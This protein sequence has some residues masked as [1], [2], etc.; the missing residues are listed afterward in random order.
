[1]LVKKNSWVKIETILLNPEERT[2]NLPD[3]T[4]KVPYLYHSIGYLKEDAKIGDIVEIKTRIGRTLKGKLIEV[5]P[6]FKH[7]FGDF[8]QELI[9]INMELKNEIKNL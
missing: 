4:K 1:M 6:S 5:N 3:D 9:D 8:V 2:A 7:N